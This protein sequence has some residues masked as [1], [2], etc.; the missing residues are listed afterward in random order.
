MGA[1]GRQ[2]LA[3]TSCQ[4]PSFQ[5]AAGGYGRKRARGR[6][7]NVTGARRGRKKPGRPRG[8]SR[9][10]GLGAMSA[11]DRLK[12]RQRESQATRRPTQLPR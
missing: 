5:L 3:G 10:G 1:P 6:N 4:C 7:R 9:P 11:L 12:A 8:V 2:I